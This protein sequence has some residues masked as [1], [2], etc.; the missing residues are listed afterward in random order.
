MSVDLVSGA[1]AGVPNGRLESPSQVIFVP[2]TTTGNFSESSLV[3]LD[4]LHACLQGQEL[5]IL[6]GRNDLE[7]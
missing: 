5:F 1:T 6:D 7:E 2:V 3:D 4:D